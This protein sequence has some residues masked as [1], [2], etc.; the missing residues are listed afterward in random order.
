MYSIEWLV[1]DSDL[2]VR[3]TIVKLEAQEWKDFNGNGGYLAT[4]HVDETLKGPRQLEVRF[5]ILTIPPV[6]QLQSFYK[7]R[8]PL[9]VFLNESRELASKGTVFRPAEYKIEWRYS[10]E[11]FAPRSGYD[12]ESFLNLES[13]GKV[14]SFTSDLRPLKTGEQILA[15]ARTAVRTEPKSG[16]LLRHMLS[17]QPDSLKRLDLDTRS[18]SGG[19]GV[20]V[21][22]DG[23]LEKIAQGW[24]KSPDPYRR[25]TAVECLA[26]FHTGQNVAL[27]RSLTRDTATQLRT[28]PGG[29]TRE[30]LFVRDAARFLLQCWGLAIGN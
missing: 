12:E 16:R 14:E 4:V 29:T 19:F 23:R 20:T 8:K 15:A 26:Y 10:R 21:P 22:I 30:S 27:L 11:A 28:E 3:G 18:F 2:V 25:L 17:V 24:V 1:A 13:G 7:D 6:G 9:L 5:F